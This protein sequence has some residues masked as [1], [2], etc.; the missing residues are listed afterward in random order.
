M[1]ALLVSKRDDDRHVSGNRA[2]A[3][4]VNGGRVELGAG[5]GSLNSAEKKKRVPSTVQKMADG[6]AAEQRLGRALRSVYE[7]TVEESVPDEMLDLLK[8]LG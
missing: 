8:K 5:A 1:N 6:A 2:G 4:P 7:E 3:V